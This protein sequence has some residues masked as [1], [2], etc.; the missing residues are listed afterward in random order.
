[1]VRNGLLDEVC[2]DISIGFGLIEEKGN[3]FGLGQSKEGSVL[4][5]GG[6]SPN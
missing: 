2:L 1:M 3:I 4:G 6:E 5:Y